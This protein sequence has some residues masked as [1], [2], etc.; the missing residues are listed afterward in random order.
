MNERPS[1]RFWWG[2]MLAWAPWI[3]TLIGLGYAFLNTKA[4]GLAAVAGGI[5]ELLVL[6][7]FLTMLVSQAVAVIWLWRSFSRN[8]VLR[9]LFGVASI[10]VSG[11]MLLLMVFF[12]RFAWFLRR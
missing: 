3:P 11:L 9:N 1:A 10:G 2:V 5:A 8:N 7:G 6:W 12:V 4:T